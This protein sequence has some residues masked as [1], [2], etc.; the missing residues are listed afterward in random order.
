MCS[1]LMWFIKAS[2]GGRPFVFSLTR[3]I[4]SFI[5]LSVTQGEQICTT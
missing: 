1:P 5:K 3:K 4:T 2:L